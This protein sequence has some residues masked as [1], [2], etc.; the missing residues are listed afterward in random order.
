MLIQQSGQHPELPVQF[1]LDA[2]VQ[3]FLRL[4]QPPRLLKGPRCSQSGRQREKTAPPGHGRTS[5]GG[6][7]RHDGVRRAYR[8]TFRSC[9]VPPDLLIPL[10]AGGAVLQSGPLQN[11]VLTEFSLDIQHG[12]LNLFLLR[13]LRRLS[14]FLLL[15]GLIVHKQVHL[16]IGVCSGTSRS[17]STRLA[18]ILSQR[19]SSPGST[20]LLK[21]AFAAF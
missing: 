6:P 18:V 1:R 5:E 10:S 16:L 13:L 12:A 2:L 14:A 20:I 7:R 15:H 17:G 9:L 8:R 11:G 19:I 4:G 21:S 3:L